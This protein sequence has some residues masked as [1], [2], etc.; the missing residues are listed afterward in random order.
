[1]LGGDWKEILWGKRIEQVEEWG[2]GGCGVNRGKKK[3]GHGK[4]RLILK[5]GD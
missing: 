4:K 5:L 3:R 1:M 2:G